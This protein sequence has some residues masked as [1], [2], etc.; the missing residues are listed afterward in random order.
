MIEATRPSCEHTFVLLRGSDTQSWG[1]R[2]TISLGFLV[3]QEFL[4]RPTLDATE[5]LATVGWVQPA[6]TQRL[7][8][9]DDRF[10][11]LVGLRQQP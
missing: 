6:P 10:H 5:R 4:W 2:E 8:S 3:P 1:R 11:M 9:L 7:V